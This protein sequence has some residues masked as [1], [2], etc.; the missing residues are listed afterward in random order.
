MISRI[1]VTGLK[2]DPSFLFE[3]FMDPR[4]IYNGDGT[5]TDNWTGL[6]WQEKYSYPE[7]GKYLSWFEA[8]AYIDTIN[9]NRI[10]GHSDWRLPNRFEVQS[11]YE[12]NMTFESHGRTYVLH[13]N[14]IFEFSYGSCY[15]TNHTRLSAALGFEFDAGEIF[16]YPCSS[17]SGSARGV[18]LAMN[19]FRLLDR[20]NQKG[21]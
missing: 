18:R 17:E 4:Y 16:W 1:A 12:M 19:P 7:N 8:E 20:F 15:W 3:K 5:V 14:P 2:S 6:M 10:G 21:N 13:M 11:L 9:R